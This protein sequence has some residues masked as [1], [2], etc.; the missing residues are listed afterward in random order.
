MGS[1]LGNLIF[2]PPGLP[3]SGSH[4]PPGSC[5]HGLNGELCSVHF[6]KGPWNFFFFPPA[7]RMSLQSGPSPIQ[8]GPAPPPS[9]LQSSPA[10]SGQVTSPK[11]LTLVFVFLRM[12][13]L[14]SSSVLKIHCTILMAGPHINSHGITLIRHEFDTN[15]TRNRSNATLIRTSSTRM[16]SNSH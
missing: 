2:W 8:S 6:H 1:N 11:T 12:V 13:I 14:K 5:N 4:L 7:P 15:S 16:D 9:S 10:W 3:P